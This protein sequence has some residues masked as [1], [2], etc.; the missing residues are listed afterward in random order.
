MVLC[1]STLNKV[2]TQRAAWFENYPQEDGMA[3][4]EE[5]EEDV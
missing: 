3:G 5:E 2:K 4:K 1:N